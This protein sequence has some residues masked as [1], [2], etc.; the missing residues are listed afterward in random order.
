MNGTDATM[1]LACSHTYHQ[2]CM[3]TYCETQSIAVTHV[4]CPECKKTA[5]DLQAIEDEQPFDAGPLRGLPTLWDKVSADTVV[6]VDEDESGVVRGSSSNQLVLAEAGANAST[7]SDSLQL[8]AAEASDADVVAVGMQH[9]KFDVPTIF[10][11]TCGGQVQPD[12]VRLTSKK[13]G[14]WRCDVCSTRITQL[15]R[16]FGTWPPPGFALTEAEKMEFFS[17]VRCA[18]GKDVVTKMKEFMET[19]HIQEA[20]YE[21]SG[22]FLPLSVWAAR[23]FDVN[24]IADKSDAS[25]KKIHP[26]LGESFRVRI[27]S[28]GTRGSQGNK[29]LEVLTAVE[30]KPKQQRLLHQHVPPFADV[31]AEDLKDEE[32]SANSIGS[33]VSD[34]SGADSRSNSDSESESR[35]RPK[36]TRAKKDKKKRASDRKHKKGKKDKKHKKDKSP[37]RVPAS[38]NN[39]TKKGSAPK[40]TKADLQIARERAVKDKEAAAKDK[41]KQTLATQIIAKIAPAM[42]SLS[43]TMA[44]P[45][46]L[47]LPAFVSD[48][49]RESWRVLTNADKEAKLVLDDPAASFSFTSIKEVTK[50]LA[51]ARKTE[52]IMNHMMMTM[53]KLTGAA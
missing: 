23:G 40:R 41:A 2:V 11:S 24:A 19:H 9:P 37:K 34:E 31:Q 20:F 44:K 22:E 26:V 5:A 4:R 45:Q 30:K 3:K 50:I 38:A 46:T 51:E 7:S 15:H 27:L 48:A 6:E 36:H 14:T 49:A 13:A 8:V 33:A 12:R 43:G 42:Q 17:S 28:A 39:Q 1:A 25:D 47:H 35:S 16:G 18:S 29:R 53:S 52:T 21:N 10:C 32:A